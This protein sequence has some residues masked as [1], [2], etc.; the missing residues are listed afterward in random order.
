MH[1]DSYLKNTGAKNVRGQMAKAVILLVIS[2][3]LISFSEEFSPATIFD[4]QSTGWVLWLSYAR[5]LIQPF[6]FYFLIC[7]GER[8]LKN[9]RV[10]ALLAFAVPAVLETAQYFYYRVATGHYVGVFDPMDFVM[11]AIGVGLAVL[12]EQ[13]VFAKLLIFWQQ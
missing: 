2:L 6:A 9:W 10:R 11:Y 13:R 12:L 7:L 3:G 4:P 1:L 8:W 5:D